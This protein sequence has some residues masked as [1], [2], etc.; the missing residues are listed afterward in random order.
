MRVGGDRLKYL[1]QL[2]F[3]TP[4]IRTRF[5]ARNSES[6][7]IRGMVPN[8]VNVPSET[9]TNSKLLSE[10]LR[11]YPSPAVGTVVLLSAPAYLEDGSALVFY[12]QLDARGGF[13]R[14]ARHETRWSAADL[15]TWV[16]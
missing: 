8:V 5:I 11:W 4:E 7:S 12:H 16:E 6:L 2:R 3:S 10:F 1:D 15:S 9:V 13:I 14:L